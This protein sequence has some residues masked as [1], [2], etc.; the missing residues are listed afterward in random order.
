MMMTH[1]YAR[2]QKEKDEKKARRL[3]LLFFIITVLILLFPWMQQM[4]KDE[5]KYDKIITIKFDDELMAAAER[6]SAKEASAS[7]KTEKPKPTPPKPTKVEKPK[8]KPLEKP[9]PKIDIPKSKIPPILKTEEPEDPIVTAPEPE[10]EPEPVEEI[11]EPVEEVVEEVEEV[12]EE[13]PE[14]VVEVVEEVEEPVEEESPGGIADSGNSGGSGNSTTSNGSS[15]SAGEGNSGSSET[16]D[17]NTDGKADSGSSGH[18]FEGD[19]VITRRVKKRPDPRVLKNLTEENGKIVL[20]VCISQEGRIVYCKFNEDL[21]TIDN[22][23]I[24]AKTISAAKTYVYYK[25]YYAAKRE[26]G[27][28]NFSFGGIE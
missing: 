6:S 20:N 17:S 15:S 27:L 16:G 24:V 8:P 25:D 11:P 23:Y 12:V 2:E 5:P 10:P 22:P 3:A 13:V 1:A 14:E 4:Q 18:D 26:C 28:L 7:K 21:S 19:G 9:K